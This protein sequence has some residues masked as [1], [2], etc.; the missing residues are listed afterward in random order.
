MHSLF[1]DDDDDDDDDDGDTLELC[2]EWE[3]ESLSY[4]KW[5]K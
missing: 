4:A 3:G 5:G 1:H 2:N